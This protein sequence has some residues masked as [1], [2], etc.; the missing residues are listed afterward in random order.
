MNKFFG[1]NNEMKATCIECRERNGASKQQKRK[2]EQE[3][4]TTEALVVLTAHKE[5]AISIEQLSS[6]IYES[7]LKAGGTEDFLEDSNI[8]FTIKQTLYID[9]LTK[10]LLNTLSKEETYQ[11][12]AGQII[13]AVSEGDGY[14]YVYYSKEIQQ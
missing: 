9:S 2:C 5:N 11:K 6:I 7:L 13:A 3:Q 1:K 14:Q 10:N 4:S 12:I 8:Q